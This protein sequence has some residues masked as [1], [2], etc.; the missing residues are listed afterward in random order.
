MQYGRVQEIELLERLKGND[1]QFCTDGS[2]VPGEYKGN[3][4]VLCQSCQTPAVQL[5]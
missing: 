1:C 3:S 5:W 4:A 2:L